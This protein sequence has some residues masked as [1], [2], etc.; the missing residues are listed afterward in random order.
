VAAASIAIVTLI[1]S[2]IDKDIEIVVSIAIVAIVTIFTIVA[3]IVIRHGD[4]H[5]CASNRITLYCS[6][7]MRLNIKLELNAHPTVGQ[8][9]TS[10]LTK[11]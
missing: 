3:V 1:A 11:A 4:M 2:F 6:I 10:Y 8:V 5:D 7:T 9:G